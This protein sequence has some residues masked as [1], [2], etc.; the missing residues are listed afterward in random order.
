M[1]NNKE[2]NKNIK[3]VIIIIVIVPILIFI[4]DLFNLGFTNANILNNIN[5]RLD[6]MSFAGS[7]GGAIISFFGLF[8]IYYLQN[9]PNKKIIEETERP[10]LNVDYIVSKGKYIKQ[11]DEKG[12]VVMYSTSIGE[13]RDDFEEN[14]EYLVIK[15][16]NTGKGLANINTENS[17][18]N[19]EAKISAGMKNGTEHYYSQKIR[20]KLNEVIKRISIMSASELY[21]VIN[22]I[23]IYQD[24][25]KKIVNLNSLK[26]S[27]IL[28]TDLYGNK[29][30][31][32]IEYV[33]GKILIVKDNILL[34]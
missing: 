29:Y 5:E 32:N 4:V 9:N 18:I 6:W 20:I 28:Y 31:D 3:W 26:K 14:Q 7:Y 2:I 15:I 30:E 13:F 22:D 21:I 23:E 24:V 27:Q 19:Y 25:S 1:K 34:K 8:V 17:C 10:F 33:N 16:S 12:R 11:E